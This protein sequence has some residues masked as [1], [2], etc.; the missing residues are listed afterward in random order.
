MTQQVDTFRAAVET[1]AAPLVKAVEDEM[2]RIFNPRRFG[3]DHDSAWCNDCARHVYRQTF[4]HDKWA[5]SERCRWPVLARALALY[6]AGL[7][8]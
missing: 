2:Q 8:A 3:S 4:N 5:H 7:E 6:K 1:I